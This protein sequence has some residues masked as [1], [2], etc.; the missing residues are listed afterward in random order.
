MNRITLIL[1]GMFLIFLVITTNHNA[2]SSN[3]REDTVEWE[4]FPIINYDQDAGFGYGGKGFL[5]NLLEVNESYDLIICNS[6]KGERWYRFVFSIPDLL[7]RHGEKYS[8]ALDFTIDYD[9]WI[10]YK[11]YPDSYSNESEY[12]STE[13]YIR[14]PI[15]LTALF[16]R[17]ITEYFAAELGLRFKSLSCYGFDPEGL[18]KNIK[19]LE[20]QYLS[21]LFNLRFD[22]RNNLINPQSGFVFEIANELAKDLLNPYEQDFYKIGI[23]GNYFISLFDPGFVLASRAVIQ[24]ITKDNYI[25]ALPLGGNNTIRG[26]PQ[27]RYLSES[28]LLIN[29]ELRFHIW[30]RFGGIAGIDTGNSETTPGWIINPVAGL[31]FYMDNFVVRFDIGFGKE[32]TGLYFNF[33]HI[34]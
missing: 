12:N 17:G 33:G 27:D 8:L 2:Q 11:F 7:R 28:T 19:P 10:K 30:W 21:L 5:Y 24:F 6:T 26:L 32:E 25:L 20:T 22:T 1:Y 9:K 34:F 18:L 15:E 14:E 3:D 29:N 4:L 16:S 23:T 13:N 31:R